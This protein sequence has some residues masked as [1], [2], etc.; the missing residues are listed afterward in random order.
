MFKIFDC[1]CD[2]LTKAMTENTNL[3]SNSLHVDI[4]RLCAFEKAVQ[5]FAIW[6]D[7]PFLENAFENTL[8]AIDFYNEQMEKYN[9]EISENFSSFLSVE[10]GEATEGSIEKLCILHE[11]GVKLMTLTWNHKNEIGCGALSGFDEGLSAFGKSVVAKMNALGMIIDVSH[12][13]KKGFYDV[14]KL[15]DKPFMATHSNSFAVCAHPRNLDDEQLKIMRDMDCAV[16]INIYPPFVDGKNGSLDNIIR[17][18][19]HM[20]GIIGEKNIG[21]GCD[22]DGIAVCPEGIEDISGIHKLYERIEAEWGRAFAEDVFYYN[23]F[24]FFEKQGIK[25][26]E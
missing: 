26:G 18:I 21:L 17:H 8:K 25:I 16:G 23:M 19:D 12:L 5:N 10:G 7:E 1:H 22:F 20:A 4:K 15:S 9:T 3:Y 11:K 14:A 24:A 6:L 2:T 13:N